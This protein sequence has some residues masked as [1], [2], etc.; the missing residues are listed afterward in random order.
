MFTMI[1][2]INKFER[3]DIFERQREKSIELVKKTISK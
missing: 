2:I 3:T 1:A